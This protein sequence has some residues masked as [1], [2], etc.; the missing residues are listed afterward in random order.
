MG[1]QVMQASKLNTVF[2]KKSNLKLKGRAVGYLLNDPMN[3]LGPIGSLRVM[4]EF[5]PPD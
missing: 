4:S 3:L 1:D 5:E 2:V